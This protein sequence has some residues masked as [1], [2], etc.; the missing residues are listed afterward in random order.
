MMN[1]AKINKKK[2]FIQRNSVTSHN[3]FG[4]IGNLNTELADNLKFD[5]G[6]DFRSYK[7]LHYRNLRDKLGSDGYRDFQYADFPN[8]KLAVEEYQWPIGYVECFGDTDSEEKIDRNNNGIID[9]FGLYFQLEY[10]G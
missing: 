7:G 10:A 5:I 1:T 4:A 3:W 8:G 9:Y 2:W 6:F